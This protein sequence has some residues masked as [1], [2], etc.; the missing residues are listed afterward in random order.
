MY[1]YTITGIFFNATEIYK[2]TNTR[3]CNLNSGPHITHFL[4]LLLRNGKISRKSPFWIEHPSK[5]SVPAPEDNNK[6]T[7]QAF[8]FN[9]I[10][11]RVGVIIYISIYYC[12]QQPNQELEEIKSRGFSAEAV[13]LLHTGM[14]CRFTLASSW[15]TI[16]QELKKV[17]TRNVLFGASW[18]KLSKLCGCMKLLK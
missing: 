18:W 1:L 11:F 8:Y 15:K 12:Y 16:Y 4:Q 17:K 7:S 2:I 14:L 13:W 6:V 9:I 5:H 3:V 10:H